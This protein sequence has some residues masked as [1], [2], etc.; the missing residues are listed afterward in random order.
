[1]NA[2]IAQH[3][4]DVETRLI[5]S[6]AIASYRVLR[7]EVAPSDGKLLVKGETDWVFV[8]TKTGSPRAI[9]EAVIQIFGKNQ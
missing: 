1:M 5:A 2:F 9:S 4:D 7:R 6:P 3:F 8:D